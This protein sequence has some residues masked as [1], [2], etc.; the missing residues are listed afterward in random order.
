M[1]TE[2][3]D[4]NYIK[5]AE[6]SNENLNQHA[7]SSSVFPINSNLPRSQMTPSK[8]FFLHLKLLTWKNYL[9][10]RRS[11]KTSLCQIFS[12]IVLC[13]I[14][15]GFQSIANQLTNYTNVNPSNLV[16]NPLPP[17]TPGVTDTC[18]TLGYVVIVIFCYIYD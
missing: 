5:L 7:A 6:N 12:P 2:S 13:L 10:H 4:I 1:A 9:V 18:T 3:S 15:L 8:Q 17:C 11:L 16:A 14:L